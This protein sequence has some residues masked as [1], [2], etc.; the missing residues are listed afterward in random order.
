MGTYTY[1]QK[2]AFKCK[3]A[4]FWRKCCFCCVLGVAF[5]VFQNLLNLEMLLAIFIFL[6]RRLVQKLFHFEVMFRN[7]PS[8]FYLTSFQS[9]IMFS[10]VNLRLLNTFLIVLFISRTFQLDVV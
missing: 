9:S 4:L 5:V 8:L 1:P 10:K 3:K 2:L 6:I 7:V